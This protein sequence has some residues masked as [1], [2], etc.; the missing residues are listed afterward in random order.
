MAYVFEKIVSF[1]FGLSMMRMRISGFLLKTFRSKTRKI[2]EY[3]LLKNKTVMQIIVDKNRH[4][5]IGSIKEKDEF[6]PKI[7]FLPPPPSCFS[8]TVRTAPVG[9]SRR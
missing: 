8:A 6:S 5:R 7:A 2:F 1:F 4:V 3:N 9:T